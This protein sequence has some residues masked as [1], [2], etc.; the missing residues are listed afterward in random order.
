MIQPNKMLQNEI[1]IQSEADFRPSHTVRSRRPI[2][3]GFFQ[4]HK[5]QVVAQRRQPGHLRRKRLALHR[6]RTIAAPFKVHH[7]M[8]LC[9]SEIT[10]ICTRAARPY[11]RP[12]SP[13]RLGQQRTAVR[14]NRPSTWPMP[15][16]RPPRQVGFKRRRRTIPRELR[17]IPCRASAWC[18]FSAASTAASWSAG[19]VLGLSQQP[20]TSLVQPHPPLPR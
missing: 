14:E 19:C 5:M 1:V 6:L 9:R 16:A 18:P 4:H 3:Q 17:T 2:S 8:R 15:G 10:V 13:L 11:L 7:A 20:D 12:W